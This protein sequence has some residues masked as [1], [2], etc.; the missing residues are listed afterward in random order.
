MTTE[1]RHSGPVFRLAPAFEA[2]SARLAS[3]ALCEVRLQLDARFAW[4]ILIPRVAEAVEI[5]DLTHVARTRLMEEIVV[6][7]GAVR[8]MGEVLGRSVT[9]LNIGALGNVT[10]Q[11]HVHVVGRR[12]D[13]D[14]WPGPVWGAGAAV[15]YPPETL[16]VVRAVTLRH[17]AV[18][19]RH[20]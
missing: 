13:D 19:R 12:P 5:E 3:L 16:S 1:I 11:L 7:G 18:H 10:P 8:A 2:G 9:K 14:A 20:T 4:L 6:A 15:A 17:L